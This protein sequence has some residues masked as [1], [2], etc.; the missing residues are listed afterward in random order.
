[1]ALDEV[2]VFIN[3]FNVPDQNNQLTMTTFS[4]LVGGVYTVGINPAMMTLADLNGDGTKDLVVADG[5]GSDVA[6]LLGNV[7][8]TFRAATYYTVGTFPS[9]VAVGDLN[10]DGIP[11]LAVGNNGSNN[12]SILLG[13]GNGTFGAATTAHIPDSNITSVAVGNFGGGATETDIALTDTL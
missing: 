4:Q 6:V 2:H 11:D 7:N 5:G 13:N 12:V 3:Q 8:G 10:G 1:I 9:S